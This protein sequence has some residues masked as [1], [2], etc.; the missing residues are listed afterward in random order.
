MNYDL[1]TLCKLKIYGE[2]DLIILFISIYSEVMIWDC[3]LRGGLAH[4]NVVEI[5]ELYD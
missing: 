3:I 4:T 1:R 5:S 2:K